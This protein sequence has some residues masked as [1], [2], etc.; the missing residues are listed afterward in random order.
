MEGQKIYLAIPQM[1]IGGS[2]GCIDSVNVVADVGN[3]KAFSE[4]ADAEKW[5]EDNPLKN[6]LEWEIVE[7]TVC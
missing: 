1:L 5:G 4:K 2:C 7:M 3:A 6:N